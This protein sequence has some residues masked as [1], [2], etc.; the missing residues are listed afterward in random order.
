M[1]RTA[2]IVTDLCRLCMKNND[3]Y[4]NI[5]TSDVACRV[6]V[7]D[8]MHGLLGL[9]VA[10]GDGLPTTLCPVC[11]NKLT[12][13]SVFKKI[14]LESDANLRKFCGSNYSR[15][16]QGD[17]AAD[18][19]MGSSADT[20]DFIQDKIQGSSHL[21]CPV[22]MTEIYIPELDSHQPRANMLFNLKEES[23]DPLSEGNYSLMH[24]RD[25]A[26]I[27]TDV[28]DPLA[29]DDWASKSSQGEGADAEGT[30][31]NLIDGDSMLVL[32]KK[33][34][35]PK[36]TDAAEP[37]V[38]E[39]GELVQNGT[40]GMESMTEAVELLATER[41]SAF[42]ALLEPK[43][44]ASYSRKGKEN[45]SIRKDLSLKPLVSRRDTVSSFQSTSS[46]S[47][48]QLIF[49]RQGV[50]QKGNGLL[51]INFGETREK[52]NVRKARTSFL[53]DG[54]SCTGSHHTETKPYS[55]SE[56]EKSFSQWSTLACHIW[57]HTKEK[58]YPCKECGKS[59]SQKGSLVYHIRTHTKEKPY[60]CN[61]CEKSFFLRGNL[62][63][64]IRTHTKEKP[65][66]CNECDKSFSVKGNLV[67]HI[68]TH[69]KE[70]PFH[71]NEC[72]KPF[73]RKSNL[74]RHNRCHTKEKPFP[75]N[76]CKKSFSVKSS[77]VRHIRTHMKEKPY[78][79]NE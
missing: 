73:S 71:C 51:K 54:K 70:K 23:E 57:A 40:M 67:A 47:L 25:P 19:K 74:V 45:L 8:A 36:E 46:R 3:Y 38:T 43:V 48:N 72:G 21:T 75:C 4:Y 31:A 59:F 28:Q 6:T 18:D 33:E 69:T 66:S 1:N 15:S 16:F 53:V 68:L 52:R 78:P 27:S 35:S 20:K 61:E 34:L 49:K 2:G 63:A 10:V 12:E 44:E 76:E 79:C 64:H 26:I 24:T 13:F 42:F 41:A 62:V 7:K 5:F 29:T 56:C 58:P 22:Q 11:W 9:E 17:E 55:C 60:S 39:N 30:G 50:R 77:L 14:C 32:A 65:Y 37:T